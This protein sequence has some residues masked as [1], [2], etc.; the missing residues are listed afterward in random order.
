VNS[1]QGVAATRAARLKLPLTEWRVLVVGKGPAGVA[2][3]QAAA[4]LGAKVTLVSRSAPDRELQ[5]LLLDPGDIAHTSLDVYSSDPSTR[6]AFEK[7][8]AQNDLVVNAAELHAETPE[9]LSRVEGDHRRFYESLLKA[10]FTQRENAEREREGKFPKRVVRV[11]SPPAE[12]PIDSR[13][14]GFE[15]DRISPQHLSW[16][17]END[18]LWRNPYFRGKVR[19]SQLADELVGRGLDL[20]TALPT[21]ILSEYADHGPKLEFT[22]WLRTNHP[23]MMPAIPTDAV[24]GEIAGRGMLLVGLLGEP[25]DRYQLAGIRTDSHALVDSLMREAGG[26]APAKRN[27]SLEEARHFAELPVRQVNHGA[28]AV[29]N[30]L[31]FWSGD[32]VG[33]MRDIPRGWTDYFADL[34]Y[35]Q[36]HVEPYQVA[37]G[38]TMGQRSSDKARKLSE[39]VRGTPYGALAYPRQDEIQG[40]FQ[41]TIQRQA[42]WLS[43]QGLLPGRSVKRDLTFVR[44]RL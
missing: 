8:A 20:T 3:A 32:V 29:S 12:V 31:R 14:T 38:A 36:Y 6:R 9:Q 26:R 23:P 39:Q 13:G 7:L 24:P 4:R 2:A 43:S 33:S 30:I 41:D 34:G 11:G 15:E 40:M 42:A 1:T 17:L 21:Q 35:Q 18:L 27:L 28:R 5:R 19:S 25:G 16:K 22:Q 10:G 44:P 37:L